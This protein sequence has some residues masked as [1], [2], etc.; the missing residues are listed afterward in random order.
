MQT[1]TKL[2]QTRQTIADSIGILTAM[3]ASLDEKMTNF[4]QRTEISLDA[5][6]EKEMPAFELPAE[7][8]K[9]ESIIYDIVSTKDAGFIDNLAQFMR[10]YNLKCCT[11]DYCVPQAVTA[12]RR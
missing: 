11:P 7:L 5:S 1:Y 12:E 2:C 6:T 8:E 10:A 4:V 3:L 9:Y